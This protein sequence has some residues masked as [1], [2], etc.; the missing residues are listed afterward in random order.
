MNHNIVEQVREQLDALT[1]AREQA[2]IVTGWEIRELSLQE[3]NHDYANDAGQNTLIVFVLTASTEAVKVLED[4][5]FKRSSPLL[6]VDLHHLQ[7]S[8]AS[9]DDIPEGALLYR[10]QEI[11]SDTGFQTGE[12]VVQYLVDPQQYRG[13]IQ[14]L[15]TVIGQLQ[16]QHGE[17]AEE[18]EQ[19]LAAVGDEELR[20]I[21]EE[22][23][24]M[25]ELLARF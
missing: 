1:G 16:Q 23:N 15:V 9:F 18:V 7:Q 3:K 17:I 22:A 5:F 2:E 19:G 21:I 11:V 20:Q 4:K 14:A 24:T 8:G 13:G 10:K 12:R 25:D 6:A